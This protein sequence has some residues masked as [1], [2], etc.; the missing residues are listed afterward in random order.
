VDS[1]AHIPV[2]QA[3]QSKQS[4]RVLA[5]GFALFAMFFGAGNLVFP[6]FLGANAGGHIAWVAV[7]F[8]VVGVGTPLLGLIATS[9]YKGSYW[10]FFGRLGKTPA[11]LIITFLMLVIGPFSAAPR[12]EV[13]TYQSLLPFLPHFLSN[14]W[15]F[16]ALFCGITFICAM[17]ETKIVDV[18]GYWITPVKLFCFVLLIVLGILLVGH[19]MPAAAEHSKHIVAKSVSMGY[20]TM[21]MLGAFFFATIAVR[22][23]AA[24]VPEGMSEQQRS[25]MVI[26]RLLKSCVVAAVLLGLIYFGFMLAA[27]YHSASLTG[28]LPDKMLHAVS[29]AILGS[30]GSAFVSFCV[31]FAC[32]ATSIALADVTS[33]YLYEHVVRNRIPRV[34]CMIFVLVAMFLMTQLGFSG[35]MNFAYPILQVIYPA[36]IVLC[37]VN[38]L[39]KTTGF[40]WVKTPVVLTAVVS[41]VLAHPNLL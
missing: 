2:D 31:T 20:G 12:T 35:I 28:L 33:T 14:S 17:R 1:T 8:I 11:F 39:H 24:R 38:I 34:Y 5:T 3:A 40:K 41:F 4:S 18:I 13:I 7:L 30:Y 19:M 9:L 32:L 22:A 27:Y 21:D 15:V 23:I 6:L 26:N 25:H 16:S 10:D 36:L 29:A 37:I